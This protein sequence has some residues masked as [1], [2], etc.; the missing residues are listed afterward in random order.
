MAAHFSAALTKFT[1]PVNW[2]GTMARPRLLDMA[3]TYE[4]KRFVLVT[5]AA[6]SGKTTF[7]SQWYAALGEQGRLVAWLSL[8]ERDRNPGR[9]LSLL[10]ESLRL[11][12]EEAQLSGERFALN[13]F[14]LQSDD[15]ID[16]FVNAVSLLGQRTAVFIDDYYLAATAQ[17]DLCLREILRLAPPNL[18]IVLSSRYYPDLGLA[19]L[20]AYSAMAEVDFDQL[21]FDGDETA[22]FMRDVHGI[23]ISRSRGD[24]LCSRTEGWIAGLQLASLS[25]KGGGGPIGLLENF[26]GSRREVAD[27]LGSFVLDEQSAE[28]RDFLFHTALLDR[29]DCNLASAVTGRP[30]AQ[31]MIEQIEAAN[32]FIVPLDDQRRWYR[33]HHLFQDF[34][35]GRAAWEAIDIPAV[36]ALAVRHCEEQHLGE[37]AV[38]YALA[39]KDEAKAAD[40]IAQS[41]MALI[42]KGDIPRLASWLESV[43]DSV[44]QS[45]PRLP[46]I[47][48]WALF[49]AGQSEAGEAALSKI[50]ETCGDSADWPEIELL[51]VA[52]DI[53]ADEL[54]GILVRGGRLLERLEEAQ[55]FLAGT[56]AN[57]ITIS[58]I[59]L[60]DYE[61]AWGFSDRAGA[62]HQRADCPYGYSFSRCT[63]AICLIAE[64]KADIADAELAKAEQI[65]N[66]TAGNISFS[67]ALCRGLRGVCAYERG[68]LLTAR[69][70]L[71]FAIPLIRRCGNIE[72]QRRLAVYLSRTC[73]ALG[74]RAAAHDMLD[75][76][77]ASRHGDSAGKTRTTVAAERMRLLLG[78]ED[79]RQVQLIWADLKRLIEREGAVPDRLFFDIEIS[80]LRVLISE[81]RWNEA[82]IAVPGLALKLE[83]QQNAARQRTELLLVEAQIQ[84]GRQDSVAARRLAQ[85]AR[86]SG[87]RFPMLFQ[88]APD[89]IRSL[90]NGD[91]E[92]ERAEPEA[93]SA[94][95]QAAIEHGLSARE[96]EILSLVI[97][98]YKNKWIARSLGLSEHTVKW[99]VRNVLEKLGAPNRASAG[100]MVR[101]I[102]LASSRNVG[103]A[104]RR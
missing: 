58:R 70:H 38:A 84:I 55:P 10:A 83:S 104:G 32:L 52:M 45:H 27:Y 35:R 63:R 25:L 37:D 1:P 6:G 12:A 4:D 99:H 85:Q 80:R 98:G 77:A 7:M 8:D 102:E 95:Q 74:D 73:A 44:I 30:D 94:L 78:E 56:L 79:T 22:A 53:A 81:G 75:E 39:S 97:E 51:Q 46:I 11:A 67:A 20:R 93:S 82:L 66:R 28:V 86:V 50:A 48:C 92:D 68:D 18:L 61:T 89:Q 43:S 14:E 17:N 40:L 26:A 65:A 49:H 42:Y 91:W 3:R 5:A 47:R 59:G 33:Y 101:H 29:F 24:L 23:E 31:R 13:G 88:E 19:R 87:E 34:L 103:T 36:Y 90:L 54:E 76:L 69:Q 2:G 100:A 64:G 96:G 16:S 60:D 15:F 41:A 21:R 71:E 9:L 72:I 62:L 57:F